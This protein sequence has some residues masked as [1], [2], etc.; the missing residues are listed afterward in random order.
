MDKVGLA[1]I[2]TAAAG[3]SAVVAVFVQAYF[4]VMS[5]ELGERQ[6]ELTRK[7]LEQTDHLQQ[8]Q[9]WGEESRNLL[10]FAGRVS[11]GL[12]AEDGVIRL[13][14]KNENTSPVRVYTLM[15]V[16]AKAV[17]NWR[18]DI[19]SCEETSFDSPEG[20]GEYLVIVGRNGQYLSAGADSRVVSYDEIF[21]RFG[22]R[23]ESGAVVVKYDPVPNRA[24]SKV[25]PC[26]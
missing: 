11:Y 15:K 12:F 26:T 14:V 18:F 21:A 17:K 22:E 3:L 7:Q 2:G 13:K 24:V 9:W 5:H 6:L 23:N 19:A 16:G 4:S 20:I 10:A 25:E 1:N 8:R